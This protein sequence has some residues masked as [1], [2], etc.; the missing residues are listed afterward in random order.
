MSA[1]SDRQTAFTYS[2]L[3]TL[4]VM[5]LLLSSPAI[6]SAAVIEAGQVFVCT[7][8]AVWDGDGPVLCRE[9]PILRLAGIAAREIDG[10]CRPGQP[11]SAASGTQARDTLVGLLGGA[12]GRWSDGH[13]VV[14]PPAMRC[15]SAGSGKGER[16][17]AWCLLADGRNLSCSMMATQT[18]LRWPRYDPTNICHVKETTWPR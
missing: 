14:A 7:P 11:C 6:P 17:A 3:R 13:I 15:L 2:A 9:G 10:T 5:L 4:M 18:V 8:V 16:T 1:M 12:K